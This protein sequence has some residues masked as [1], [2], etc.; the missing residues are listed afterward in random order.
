ML[1]GYTN[2]NNSN[3]TENKIAISIGDGKEDFWIN[4][5]SW[6]PK[7]GEEVVHP[8]WILD[9][10][11]EKPVIILAH[12]TTCKPCKDQDDAIKE[13]LGDLGDSIEY[14]SILTDGGDDR[15]KDVYI[16]YYPQ[17]G[18]WYIP[19][20]VMLSK[21][22]YNGKEEVIWHSVIGVTSEDWLREYIEN[23]I[24]YYR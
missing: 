11:D 21:T 19:L 2:S 13:V 14:I 9:I 7:H 15:M 6:H 10:L 12:S 16:N 22:E 5:P 1:G 4:H 24:E 18:Q 17:G 20:T 23:A 3:N 8:Q